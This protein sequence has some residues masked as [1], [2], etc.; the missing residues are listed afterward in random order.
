M[1][2]KEKSCF[3]YFLCAAHSITESWRARAPIDPARCYLAVGFPPPGC[4]AAAKGAGV[5]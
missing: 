4:A 5:H 3:V 2:N 1:Q